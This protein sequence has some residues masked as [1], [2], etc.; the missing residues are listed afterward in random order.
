MIPLDSRWLNTFR[1][2]CEEDHFTRAAKRLNMTQPG[3]SQHLA[4]LEGQVGQQLVDRDAP[5]FTLTDTG[6][7]LRELADRR[8]REEQAL[9]ETMAAGHEDAGIVRVASSGSFAM[10]LYPLLIQWMGEA[11]DLRAE[12][13]AAPVDRICSGV[14]DG[15]FDLGVVTGSFRHPRIETTVLGHEPLDLLLPAAWQG[16]SPDFAGLQS[17]GFVDHPDG[18][19]LA[20]I[21]FDANFPVDYAGSE[22]IAVRTAINQIGQIPEAV[23]SGLAYTI[24]PR[25][26]V[27]TFPRADRLFVPTMP[28][29]CSLPLQAI[30]LKG[31]THIPRLA[32]LIRLVRDQVELFDRLERMDAP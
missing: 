12:L 28:L 9:R 32:K 11:P 31:R 25:S 22:A 17:L 16:R 24:L 7:A 4:K 29:P 19:A 10:L 27:V 30:C 1:V 3:V 20:D 5:S 6:A 15:E 8:W 13:T 2:L 26:G 23:A 18:K 21:V 14:V